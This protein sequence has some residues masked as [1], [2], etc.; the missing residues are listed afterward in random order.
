MATRPSDIPGL[1]NQISNLQ[2]SADK[3]NSRLSSSPTAFGG[4]NLATSGD[5]SDQESLARINKEI[6]GLTDTKLKTQWYGTDKMQKSSPTEGESKPG[7]IGS[8]LDFLSRPLYGVVGAVKHTIGKGSGSLQQDVADNMVRNKNTFSDVLKTSGVHGSIAAPLGFALD[9]AM[10]PV[11]WATVGTSALIP[12]IVAGGVKGI[13]T[14]EGI[15]RGLALATK[16]GVL[17]KAQTVGKYTPFFR[18]SDT[19]G[20]LGDKAINATNAWEDFSGINAINLATQKG[21]GVGS[22]RIGLKEVI[23]KVA[24]AVPGGQG[25]LKHFVY[26]PSDWVRQARIKDTLQESLGAGVDLKGV[27]NAK[28][29]GEPIDRFMA[30]AESEMASKIA[31]TPVKPS[32]APLIIDME[33][34]IDNV[35]NKDIDL[36]LSKINNVG[37]GEKV[38]ASA[39]SMVNNVDDSISIMENPSAYTSVDPI[40]NAMRLASERV[41]GDPITLDEISRI[42]NSGALDET[43]VKWFDNMMGGIKNFSINIDKKSDKVISVGKTVMDNYDRAMGIFRAAKVGASPTSWVN[44]VAGNMVMAHMAN[45]DIG[46]EFIARL[47][48]SYDMYRN[49]SGAAARLDGLL[50]EA[51]KAMGD[52]NMIRN[53]ILNNKTAA[54]GTFGDISFIHSHDNAE[55]LLKHAQ[56]SG[57]VSSSAKADDIRDNLKIAMDELAEIRL[58]AGTEPVRGLYSEAAKAGK[59]VTR[60]DIGAVSTGMVSNEMINSRVTAEMFDHIAKRAAENPSNIAWKVLDFSLNKMPSGYEKIDQTFKMATFLRAT[61]D[62]YTIDQIRKM[63]HI[64]NITPEEL[65]LGKYSKGLDGKSLGENRYRL[66]SETALE[67][68]NVMYLNYNAMP[69]AV[70]V[71]RNMPIIGSPFVSFMYG[72]TLKTGQTLAYN[73]S[74]F[75]KVNFAMND[76]GGSK[77]PLEK[78][79]L[80]T[81][82]YSYLKQQGMFRVPF[83]NDNPLYMNMASM[84]PYYSLNMFNPSQTNYGNST[85]EKLTQAVQSSPLL[86]DP[87]G[88]VIFDYLI[89]PLILGEAI[90]PQGQFGQPLYPV[91][92]TGLEKAGYATRTLGEAFVPNI[93][94]YAGLLTPEAAAQ[95]IPSYRWRQLAMAK[96]GKNQM[97]ISS[98]EDPTQRTA[99]TL[100]NATGIPLQAP[101]NTSFASGDN[102]Q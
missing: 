39:P 19:F 1:E 57:I 72:M 31:S 66:S 11:N 36:A 44:A 65:S 30:S 82:S 79:S 88:S 26:D 70:R 38:T 50:M 91:D 62:G 18:K 41:K 58:K 102:Q 51:G 33:G 85:R 95:Y 28:I 67:L 40:E 87:A 16:A 89:Q 10:D 101:V 98:K 86:K 43:G 68:A 100:L 4:E 52:E 69:S 29:K 23:N 92:A 7:V 42:V 60:A 48:Q 55:V 35:T 93:T 21:L 13:Q 24:D 20:K 71:L 61:V 32:G 46:P 80:E 81:P 53:G 77:T 6:Q 34:S 8:A 64:I 63:R 74:S 59:E 54:G 25:M 78:Q 75:N 9:I 84:I 96:E 2:T 17:E 76:F 97:G 73:P 22:Y 49:K 5:I 27:I 56:D 45:G 15:G 37:L 12:K 14:G 47:K 90:R 99:R 94:S 3:Y 83:F